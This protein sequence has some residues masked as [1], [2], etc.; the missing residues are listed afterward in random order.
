MNK[1]WLKIGVIGGLSLFV[2]VLGGGLVLAK[3]PHQ[4]Q[5]GAQP[6]TK[7]NTSKDREKEHVLGA[8]T[9]NDAPA[10]RSN[11]SPTHQKNT[12]IS[13]STPDSN[14]LSTT[15][16]T[17][18]QTDSMN[19]HTHELGVLNITI[20]TDVGG[21]ACGFPNGFCKWEYSANV[22]VK[23]NTGQVVASSSSASS[24]HMFNLPAGKYTVYAQDGDGAHIAPAP[25]TV[26]INYSGSTDI[27]LFYEPL[28]VIN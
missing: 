8:T 7:S 14:G 3:Q 1:P 22:I 18:T 21:Q 19:V 17:S 13:T 10:T 2:L 28:A 11:P 23:D 24:S 20:Q 12:G 4:D 16:S 6:Y 27:T 15:P 9:R 25:V 26:D 5:Q